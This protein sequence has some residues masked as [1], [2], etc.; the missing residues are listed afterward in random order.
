MHNVSEILSAVTLLTL[1]EEGVDVMFLRRTR[2]E[3][4]RQHEEG[5]KQAMQEFSE[6]NTRRL[7]AEAQGEAFTEPPPG[8]DTV[9]PTKKKRFIFF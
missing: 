1:I 4:Q 3:R 7:E 2:E 5:Y 6:W 8:N 9:K